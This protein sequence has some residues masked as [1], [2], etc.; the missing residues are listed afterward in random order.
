MEISS[1]RKRAQLKVRA[2][3]TRL[4]LPGRLCRLR[5]SVFRS[6][7]HM[8]AQIIDDETARTLVSA[9]DVQLGKAGGR[10]L[11]KGGIK[12]A[13]LVGE[14]VAKAAL[15]KKI[16]QVVFDRGGYK[17]HGRVRAL[18]EGARKAGLKL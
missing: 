17:Y 5:L 6:G 18:A 2:R 15:E 14:A 16:T 8:Y 1:K 3:R 12:I 9:N 7:K 13:E 11:Q 10:K 4:A